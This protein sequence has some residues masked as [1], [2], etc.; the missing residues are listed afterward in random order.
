MYGIGLCYA[1][2]G[3]KVKAYESYQH[4]LTYYP[5][6]RSV[7]NNLGTAFFEEKKYDSAY[8]YFKR[9]YDADSSFPKSSQNLAIYYFTVGDYNQAIQYAS[10]AVKLFKYQVIAY[11]VLSKAY[12]A[13]G[14]EAEAAKY[15]MLY[16]EMKAEADA[17]PEMNYIM[18][19]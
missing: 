11:D 15:Q 7:L 16:V 12:K 6:H 10:N 14:N 17:A 19:R 18:E 8:S 13:V 9:S 3:D 5:K 4:A 1:S 2:L